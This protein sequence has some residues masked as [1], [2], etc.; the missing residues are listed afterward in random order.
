M[1]D[2]I[3]ILDVSRAQ[4]FLCKI[5]KTPTNPIQPYQ[6]TRWLWHYETKSDMVPI[7]SSKGEPLTMTVLVILKMSN[8]HGNFEF[9]KGGG[10]VKR[11]KQGL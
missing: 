10:F 3:E 7:T 4:A 8:H 1:I 11:N 9:L 6:L 5:Q 2:F